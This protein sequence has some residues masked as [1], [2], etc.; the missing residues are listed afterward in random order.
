MCLCRSLPSHPVSV[1]LFP[2]HRAKAIEREKDKSKSWEKER[3]EKRNRFFSP[4]RRNLV[5]GHS[6]T[7]KTHTLLLIYFSP[8]LSRLTAWLLPTN[9]SF[10][11]SQRKEG[12]R[13]R[14]DHHHTI[15][16]SFTSRYR[17]TG[18]AH[19]PPST[20][21]T[22][23]RTRKARSKKIGFLG[24]WG[25]CAQTQFFSADIFFPFLPPSSPPN[26]WSLPYLI[27][28]TDR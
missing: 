10:R 19:P 16:T 5:A 18:P 21:R 7:I 27:R 17:A 20:I 15:F 22:L 23:P 6:V 13:K 11:G 9:L 12:E 3:K 8:Y 24:F 14:G 1:F 28:P 25:L 26:P 2:L 4:R